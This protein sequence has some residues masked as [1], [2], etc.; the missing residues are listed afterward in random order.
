M[1]DGFQICNERQV[2]RALH[3]WFTIHEDQA[4]IKAEIEEFERKVEEGEITRPS[5]DIPTVKRPAHV[6]LAVQCLTRHVVRFFG[7]FFT[8]FSMLSD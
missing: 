6:I 1:G 2:L 8:I 7:T 3:Q 5:G 4:S